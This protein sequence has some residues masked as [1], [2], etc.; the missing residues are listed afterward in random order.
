MYP[1]GEITH[2]KC[3]AISAVQRMHQNSVYKL[4]FPTQLMVKRITFLLGI[5]LFGDTMFSCFNLLCFRSPRRRRSR[6]SSRSRRSRHRRSRSRSREWHWRSRSRSQERS[7]RE[8][9]RERRQKG[10]PSIKSQTLSGMCC[11]RNKPVNVIYNYSTQNCWNY[12]YMQATATVSTQCN[13]VDKHLVFD[14]TSHD[15]NNLKPHCCVFTEASSKQVSLS[16][17]LFIFIF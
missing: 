7:E 13:P 2:R 5:A 11:N 10:L 3:R 15:Y 6:S 12:Y 17:N 4:S 16:V 9:D 8:K 1:E 14:F